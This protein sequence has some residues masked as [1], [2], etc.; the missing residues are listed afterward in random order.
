MALT[1]PVYTALLAGLCGILSIVLALRISAV[2]I[3]EKVSLGDGEI[4]ELNKRI[5]AHANLLENAPVFL[6]MVGL[7]EASGF[8]TTI[9][10]ILCGLFLLARLAHAI[11]I[12]GSRGVFIFR[13]IGAAL[14][15]LLVLVTGVI[16]AYHAVTHFP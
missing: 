15:M 8:N 13:R 5:R 2:R 10:G 9:A 6:I 1:F 3:R 11:G 7:L 16:L 14:T 4:P 12:S